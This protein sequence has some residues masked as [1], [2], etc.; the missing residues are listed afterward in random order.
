[1]EYYLVAKWNDIILCEFYVKHY[2]TNYIVKRKKIKTILLYDLIY[3]IYVY[4][5]IY[6]HK[7]IG[8]GFEG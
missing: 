2:R 5:S 7:Y 3:L 8:K 6:V 4:M 1:M